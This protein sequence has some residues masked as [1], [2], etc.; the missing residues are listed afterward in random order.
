MALATIVEKRNPQGSQTAPNEAEY[1]HYQNRL[2]G[3]PLNGP[4][5]RLV[6]HP[7]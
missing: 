3:T 4:A 6:I 1:V 2:P 5:S 7:P